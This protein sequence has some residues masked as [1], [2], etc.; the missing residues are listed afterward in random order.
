[1]HPQF[2]GTDFA[3][4]YGTDG[5]FDPCSLP[6]SKRREWEGRRKRSRANPVVQAAWEKP[7]SALVSLQV[8]EGEDAPPFMVAAGMPAYTGLFG[9]DAYLTSL[10]SMPMMGEWPGRTLLRAQ[11]RGWRDARSGPLLTPV[12]QRARIAASSPHTSTR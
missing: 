12:P 6:A 5:R 9:R 7:V 2:L 4:F 11:D 8:L 1:M 10:Q 3:P